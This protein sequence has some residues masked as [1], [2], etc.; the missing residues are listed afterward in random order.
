MLTQKIRKP[1]FLGTFRD[2]ALR[3]WTRLVIGQ[4]LQGRVQEAEEAVLRG[5]SS[6]Q[7]AVDQIVF[8]GLAGRRRREYELQRLREIDGIGPKRAKALLES[9]GSLE[10][11]A[12]AS[13]EELAK[14]D[15]IKD[16]L[17]RRVMEKIADVI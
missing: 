14:V 16:I 15:G 8:R 13:F 9:F 6:P 2:S 11:V 17:A 7:E 1:V 5:L 4:E 12:E 10:A 3:I